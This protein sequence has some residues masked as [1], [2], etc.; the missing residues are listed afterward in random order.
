MAVNKFSSADLTFMRRALKLAKRG[1]YTTSPNPCVGCV[2]VRDGM[3]IAEGY[4]RKAGT[5]HAEAAALKNAGSAAAG[6]TAYV[7]LEPCSHYGRTPPCAKAL[8]KA[9]VR[10]VVAAVE[11]CNPQVAGRGM[12]MLR[13][14]GIK[15]EV[16]LCAQQALYLNRAFFKAMRT[17][18]PYVVAKSACSLDNKIALSDGRSQWITGAKAR[19]D[20]QRLRARADAI[21]TG[22]NTVLADNPQYTVRY[23]ELPAKV[24]RVISAAQLRQPLKVVLDSKGRL[25]AKADHLALFAQGN[26]LQVCVKNASAFG[27]EGQMRVITL[28]NGSELYLQQVAENWQRL[29]VDADVDGHCDLL[30]V[31][32][33]LGSL[34]FRQILVEAG[35]TLTSAFLSAHLVDELFVYAA[36]IIL[37]KNSLPAL[38]LPEPESLA[39]AH[40]QA[41][42]VKS[43]K[44]LGDDVRVQLQKREA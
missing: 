34:E 36:P 24:R 39:I 30:S 42:K 35:S 40:A 20:G 2:L 5:D 23:E 25:N 9:G 8:I 7:T 6:A 4:H 15:T 31:L 10:R 19:A 11:D 21:I 33:F 32:Y 38:A 13:E 41:F 14:A 3:V 44:R 1:R 12:R 16:G 18:L 28:K 26:V 27:Q 29:W 37:G 22:V 17:G 43:V